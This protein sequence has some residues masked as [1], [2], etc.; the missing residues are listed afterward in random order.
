MDQ[1]GDDL[2]D[3]ILTNGVEVINSR[4]SLTTFEDSRGRG[5]NIDDTLMTVDCARRVQSWRVIDEELSDHRG[6]CWTVTEEGRT[7]AVPEEQESA[8]RLNLRRADWA[9]IIQDARREFTN[10]DGVMDAMTMEEGVGLLHETM[11]KIYSENVVKAAQGKKNYRW[12]T[13]R[14]SVMRGG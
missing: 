8:R 1:R 6:I 12:W 9:R 3:F 14:I 10:F 11:W 2:E 5:D 7:R 13:P 4:Q